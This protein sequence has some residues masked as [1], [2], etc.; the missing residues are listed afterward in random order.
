MQVIAKACA[1]PKALFHRGLAY[2]R[3]EAISDAKADFDVVITSGSETAIKTMQEHFVKKGYLSEAWQYG[4][5]VNCPKP[6]S[7]A[8]WLPA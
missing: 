6:G 2:K 8:L 7:I 3:L 1:G 5:D 4:I